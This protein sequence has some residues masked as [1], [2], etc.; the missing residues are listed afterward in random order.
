MGNKKDL[1]AYI[2]YDGSGRVIPGALLLQR[3]KPKGGGKWHQIGAYECCDPFCTIPVY[4]EDFITTGVTEVVGGLVFGM[5]TNPFTNPKLEVAMISCDSNPPERIVTF[6]VTPII[7][8]VFNYFVP[9][10]ILEQSCTIGFRRV[11]EDNKS[12]WNIGD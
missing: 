12:G 10:A 11:C 9:D 4:G 1:K 8:N 7:G 2:R 6:E 5:E 3:F